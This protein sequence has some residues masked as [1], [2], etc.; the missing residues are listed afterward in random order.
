MEG[1]GWGGKLGNTF[2]FQA[3][4]IF[5]CFA[6]FS[7]CVCVYC[8]R[9]VSFFCVC[10]WQQI[11]NEFTRCVWRKRKCERE[12]DKKRRGRER[13][14]SATLALFIYH[15]ASS[16]P[17]FFLPP[18]PLAHFIFKTHSAN[19]DTAANCLKCAIP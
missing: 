13:G 14:K 6:D 12:M 10:V 16:L 4:N 8:V 19:I 7:L 11:F 17:L 9:H 18:S 3:A 2:P 1:R 5:I 15:A